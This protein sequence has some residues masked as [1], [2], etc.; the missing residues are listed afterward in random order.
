MFAEKLNFLMNIT[1]TRNGVLA[2]VVNIDASHVSRLRLG[3]RKP[4]SNQDYVYPMCV[5]FAKHLD[6]AFR[7][8]VVADALHQN[9]ELPNNELEIARILYDWLLNDGTKVQTNA[10]SFLTSF[11][12]AG[13][14]DRTTMGAPTY[15]H[16]ESANQAYYY[17]SEGKR[18]AVL[19]LLNAISKETTPQ[20]LLLFSDEDISW[21]TENPSYIKK[22]TELLSLILLKGNR[23]KIIHTINR[24]V[25]EMMEAVTKWIPVYMK[26]MIEPYY[27]PKLRDGVFQRT[28]F[29]AP[30][31]AAVISNS[32]SR[33]SSNLLNIYIE[34]PSAVDALKQEFE[35]YLSMCRPLMRIF[36]SSKPASYFE[37]H[38]TFSATK[39]ASILITSTPSFMTMPKE[40]AASISKRCSCPLFFEIW[41]KCADDLPVNLS[42][43]FDEI[44]TYMPDASVQT[45]KVPMSDLFAKTP[46][47][48]TRKEYEAHIAN[49]K[50]LSQQYENYNVYTTNLEV[51][52]VMIWGK[53]DVGVFMCN[54]SSPTT[55]FSFS[56]YNLAIIFWEYLQVQLKRATRYLG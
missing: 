50:R 16:D 56:E 7:R 43:R 1:K 45:I 49:V 23:I 28:L 12:Q 29:I 35:R 8:K 38:T 46:L 24:D 36:T 2:S 13:H 27:Y 32:V 54:S 34:N 40:V 17:G 37:A 48:Y 39:A 9:G 22:W 51:L 19:R 52:P 20:T 4:P 3:T 5:Y 6:E 21:M 25:N 14:T 47:Y 33:D 44:I 15:A 53:E 26:G 55:V 18:D 31:T 41:K 10:E 11:A 30:K 42:S